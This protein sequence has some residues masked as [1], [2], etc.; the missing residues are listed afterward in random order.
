MKG[1]EPLNTKQKRI[2]AFGCIFVI[3]ATVVTLTV[4]AVYNNTSENETAVETE[5]QK[6]TDVRPAEPVNQTETIE[7]TQ[8]VVQEETPDVEYVQYYTDADAIDIAKVLYKECRGVP[9]VT[10]QACVAWTILNRVDNQQSSI[11]DVVR[12]PRQFAFSSSTKVDSTLLELAY[13]VLERWNAEKN[14]EVEVGRVLP[15]EYIYFN[16]RN[17]HNWF[18]DK[19]SGSYNTWDYSLPSPYE[20]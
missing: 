19:F 1:I 4:S 2:I 12:S 16:G 10:E 14:G 6:D 15:K 20:S 8:E 3:I 7:E 17:G 5:T 11:H 9:S 13:D 18:R